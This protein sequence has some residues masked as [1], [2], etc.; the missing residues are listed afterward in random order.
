MT[1]GIAEEGSHLIAPVHRRGEELGSARAQHLVSGRAIRHSDGQLAADPVRVCGRGKG[2]GGL[3]LCRSTW[4]REQDLTAPKV[5]ASTR[6][7]EIRASPSRL[8]RRDR[9]KAGE[10]SRSRQ[11]GASAPHRR[12][13]S[14][15]VLSLLF[16]P[17]GV[18]P[19][20]LILAVRTLTGALDALSQ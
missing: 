12:S 19:Q 11:G 6:C 18:V 9:T 8:A 20:Y 3:V 2:D 13:G 10:R 17:E 5:E 14:H 4:D 15:V 7:R 16:P 1:I